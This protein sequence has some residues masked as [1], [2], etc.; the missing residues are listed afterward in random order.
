MIYINKKD[1]NMIYIKNNSTGESISIVPTK[2]PDGTS[3]VWKLK[4]L[5]QY[6]Q[7]GVTI[8]WF[9]HEEAE[10]IYVNQLICLLHQSGIT[11]T[12]LY[13]PFLPYGRQDKEISNETTFAREVFLEI[14]LTEMVGEVT[15]LDAHSYHQKVSSYSPESYIK[16]AIEEF[17]PN[18]IVYPDSGAYNRYSNILKGMDTLVLK[19]VRDQL[20]GEIT[21]LDFDS[22][23][24]IKYDTISKH[25]RMLI[26]DDI[27]DG[28][29]TFNAASMFLH[30]AA[31]EQGITVEVGLYVTHGIFSK[32]YEK[33]IDSGITKFYTTQSI[34]RNVNGFELEEV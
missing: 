9:F 7:H 5:D 20:T 22:K 10:L 14:L 30:K 23:P 3:Q 33:M 12:E 29:A 34:I 25:S 28:G 27:C 19:K 31:K 1:M 32:G 6:K 4:D 8:I 21:G 15:T 18:V 2:F 26:I 17:K 16:K 13:M 11:I 24:Y